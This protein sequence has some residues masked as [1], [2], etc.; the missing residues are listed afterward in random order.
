[1]IFLI[2]LLITMYLIVSYTSIYTIKMRILDFLRIILGAVFVLFIFITLMH[3]GSIKYWITLLALSLFLN[4]E[5]SNYKF[6]FN[7]KKAKLILDTFSVILA[8]MII[9]LCAIYI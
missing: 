6:K 8:I 1:M 4:I 2:A 5:I 3:L 9:V 7:D